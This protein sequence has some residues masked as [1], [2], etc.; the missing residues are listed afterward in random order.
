MAI[1]VQAPTSP[2]ID[3]VPQSSSAA[4]IAWQNGSL[5]Q[6][7]FECLDRGSLLTVMRTCRAAFQDAAEVVFR[8][9]NYGELKMSAEEVR[10]TV[11]PIA[12]RSQTDGEDLSY[13]LRL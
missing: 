4:S 13:C 2:S 11:S 1:M 5:R 12:H 6:R 9:M 3:P 10:D 7:L 8:E